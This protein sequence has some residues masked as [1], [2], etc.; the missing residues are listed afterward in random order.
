MQRRQYLD[1][2]APPTWWVRCAV[3]FLA[4]LQV[5]APTWHVCA[6]GASGSAH[7][8]QMAMAHD[9]CSMPQMSSHQNDSTQLNNQ[10]M[11]MDHCLAKLLQHV[12]GNNQ[13]RLELDFN[14]I[15]VSV[16][17]EAPADNP[18]TRALPVKQAR[19]PPSYLL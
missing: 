16:L 11:A 2:K 3:L 17:V 4:C 14:A 19:G 10:P 7:E 18:L 15:T 12:L 8:H 9:A 5:V 6:E 13:F 1:K